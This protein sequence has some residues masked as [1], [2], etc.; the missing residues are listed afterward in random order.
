VGQRHDRP[1]AASFTELARFVMAPVPD[2]RL[3]FAC[4]DGVSQHY[5]RTP[6]TY[7]L[8][9]AADRIVARFSTLG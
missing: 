7:P 4:I 1:G 9:D 8:D 6:N 3:L 5:M 2:V